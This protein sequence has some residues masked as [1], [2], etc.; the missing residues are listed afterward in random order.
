LIGFDA[1]VCITPEPISP[2]S[3]SKSARIVLSTLS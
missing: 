3:T 2:E 1:S